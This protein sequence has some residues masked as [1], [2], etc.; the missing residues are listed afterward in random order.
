MQTNF[1]I[2]QLADPELKNVERILR[3]CVHCG[4]CTATCPTFLLR[5]DELDS[6]RGRI[7]LI[8]DMLE[9][10]RPASSRVVTHLDRCLSCLGC[11]TTCPADVDYMHLIDFARQHVEKTFRRPLGERMFRGMLGRLLPRPRLFRLALLGVPLIRALS[12]ALPDALR[13]LAALAPS[14]PSS[15]KIHDRRSVFPAKSERR[16]R[17]ALLAGCVQQVLAPQI[18]AATIRLLNRNGCEVVLAEGGGCCGALNHHLGQGQEARRWAKRNIDAWT[19]EIEGGGLDAVIVNAS[20]CGTMLKVYGFLLRGEPEWA[21][22]AER[23]AKLTQDVSELLATLEVGETRARAPL[24]VA[25][26]SACSLQHGQGVSEQ[27]KA[28]LQQAGFR[29]IDIPE[30]HLCCGSAGSYNLLQPSLARALRDRKVGHIESVSPDVVATGNIGC[31]IQISGATRVPV[32]HVVELLDWAG[33]GPV[34]AALA[35]I[36]RASPT[37]HKQN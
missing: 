35:G 12:A 36:E 1:S 23:I 20:G 37:T 6:P 22:K 31:L 3:S 28:L 24:T 19:R 27:P 17:V 25:Y 15:P 21:A 2:A 30:G 33:G 10:A 29:V 11:M 9:N 18:N 7:Y 13:N 14:V 34:P 4:L 26:Q 5:G 16:M 8:M 32:L